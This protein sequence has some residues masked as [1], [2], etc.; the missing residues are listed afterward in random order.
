MRF[1]WDQRGCLACGLRKLIPDFWC[2]RNESMRTKNC[3]ATEGFHQKSH[4]TRSAEVRSWKLVVTCVESIIGLSDVSNGSQCS[5]RSTSVVGVVSGGRPSDTTAQW[6]GSYVSWRIGF[7]K[8][9][10]RRKP[11]RAQ[12]IIS[13][14]SS[15]KQTW[16]GVEIWYDRNMTWWRGSLVRV[17]CRWW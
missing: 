5:W 3:S 17:Y 2:G 7:A 14:I 16:C 1:K 6:L 11:T 15:V 8:S 13:N 10:P 9:R 4:R 12:R